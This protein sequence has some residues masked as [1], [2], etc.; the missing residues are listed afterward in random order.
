[1]CVTFSKYHGSGNDYLVYDCTKNK[2]VL[3]PENIQAFT[4]FD[5]EFTNDLQPYIQ[6]NYSVPPAPDRF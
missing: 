1:M 5:A 6:N 4:D 3:S 2:R